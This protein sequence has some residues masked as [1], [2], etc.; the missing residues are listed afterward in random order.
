MCIFCKIISREIPSRIVYEDER[1]IC[2]H[3]LQPVAP[4]HVLLI[5]KKHY[6]DILDL[7]QTEN[8]GEVMAVVLATLEK[9]VP[10]LGL[11][12]GFRLINNCKEYG[13][14]SVMHLHFHLLGKREMGQIFI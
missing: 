10:L 5:P 12:E 4:V 9:I 7:A 3:D 14:Q 8:G 1:I 11:E 13:G 6:A 2:I